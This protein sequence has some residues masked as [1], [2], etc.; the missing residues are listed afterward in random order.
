[1]KKKFF[2]FFPIYLFPNDKTFHVAKKRSKTKPIYKFTMRKTLR[3]LCCRLYL[4]EFGKSLIPWLNTRRT[5]NFPSRR[6]LGNFHCF[7]RRKKKVYK[8]S[9]HKSKMV[10]VP[11]RN[12]SNENFSIFLIIDISNACNKNNSDHVLPQ[13][14]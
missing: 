11:V 14:K 13:K 5:L 6:C 7:L 9:D 3:D 8:I 1:M 2:F 10:K 4:I 12:F